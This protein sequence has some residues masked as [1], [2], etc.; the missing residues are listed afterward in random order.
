MSIQ[1][2]GDRQED[3]EDLLVNQQQLWERQQKVFADP[4]PL[5]EI[6]WHQVTLR[7]QKSWEFCPGGV[8]VCVCVQGMVELCLTLDS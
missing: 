4:V 6:L 7:G 3:D 5:S 2:L 8:C 1:I